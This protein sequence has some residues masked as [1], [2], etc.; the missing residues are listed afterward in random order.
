MSSSAESGIFPRPSAGAVRLGQLGEDE[1][2][3][4][5][6]N[7]RPRLHHANTIGSSDRA[8]IAESLSALTAEWAEAQASSAQQSEEHSEAQFTVPSFTPLGEQLGHTL[9]QH[10]IRA[11]HGGE[12]GESNWPLESSS[13]DHLTAIGDRLRECELLGDALTQDNVKRHLREAIRDSMAHLDSHRQELGQST[14]TV[15]LRKAYLNRIGGQARLKA[16]L[17]GK[18]PD[19]PESTEKGKWVPLD[20]MEQK[21]IV[22]RNIRIAII[23]SSL[24]MTLYIIAVV[25]ST[26]VSSG[27][28]LC[29]D[30]NFHALSFLVAYPLV[31]ASRLVDTCGRAF[32]TKCLPDRPDKNVTIPFGPKDVSLVELNV[33]LYV[34]SGAPS[35]PYP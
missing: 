29:D 27:F 22:S 25:F 31:F 17:G 20:A 10:G 24:M 34:N 1:E 7:T 14:R 8:Q 26:W 15:A 30:L 18:V 3:A 28:P 23:L 19:F 33:E 21:R 4:R 11:A 5:S 2:T 9:R 13:D 6:Y 32:A 35:A 16:I 12:E